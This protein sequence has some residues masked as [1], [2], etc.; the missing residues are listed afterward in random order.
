MIMNKKIF[1]LITISLVGTHTWAGK[2]TVPNTFTSG[3]TASAVEVN[4]NFTAVANAVNDNDSNI[5][6][7]ATAISN[8]VKTFYV[9]DGANTIIGRLIDVD[10]STF[11]LITETGYIVR[12][13][14]TGTIEGGGTQ[15]YYASTDC[16]GP[17]YTPSTQIGGVVV[18]DATEKGYISLDAN[19]LNNFPASSRRTMGAFSSCTVQSNVFDVVPFNFNSPS[20]TGVPDTGFIGRLHMKQI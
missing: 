7:N 14:A 1:I 12:V 18:G 9:V 3:T 4:N 10:L 20:V 15:L 5:Q 6:M 16:T 13:N 11:R 19:E 8:M 17:A 2:V